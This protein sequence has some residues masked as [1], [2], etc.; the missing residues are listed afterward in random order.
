MGLSITKDNYAHYKKVFEVISQH[1]YKD[2]INMLPAEK[3]PLA[4][5]NSAERKSMSLARRGL[6]SGLNDFLTS[7]RYASQEQI[8]AINAALQQN[9]LPDI[10]TLSGSIEKTIE[11]ILK[12][13]KIRH[14]D[15]Y[16]I[17]K[18]IIADAD[19]ELSTEDKDMLFRC[20]TDFE[21]AGN[22]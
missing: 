2:L 9:G 3:T 4:M 15:D 16:Y 5:L 19:V 7:L 20:L 11:K 10:H 13:G 18:E 17:V 1:L 8:A 21:T 14:L 12:S 6:Q 22:R